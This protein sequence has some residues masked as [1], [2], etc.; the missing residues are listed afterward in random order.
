[1]SPILKRWQLL[2]VFQSTLPVVMAGIAVAT[3]AIVSSGDMRF[4][5]SGYLVLCIAF[6]LISYNPELN[7]E[8]KDACRLTAAALGATAFGLAAHE[9]ETAL[10]L[11]FVASIAAAVTATISVLIAGN[12]LWTL[13]IGA[14]CL[15]LAHWVH[16]CF[17]FTGALWWGLLALAAGVVLPQAMFAY[18][19]R[20]A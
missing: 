16:A 6:V 17:T 1:M 9:H 18:I 12:V 11:T 13:T 10:L 2:Y 19:M 20:H 15:F 3:A 7:V 14:V 8:V 5:V 4:A